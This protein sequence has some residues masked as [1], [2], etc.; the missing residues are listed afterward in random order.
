M[1]E[2]RQ[3]KPRPDFPLFPHRNGQWA[4][5]VR[6]RL[7]YFGRDPDAALAK[8]LDQKD[9][10]LA[11][12]SPRSKSDAEILV[13][14]AVN[15]VL[16]AKE[17][18]VESHELSPYT[19]SQYHGICKLIVGRLGNRRVVDLRPDDFIALRSAFAK[20]VGLV[21]LGNRIRIT[22]IVFRHAF[23][24]EL[25]E[26]PVKFGPTFKVPSKK[27]L[28]ADK[29]TR[30][31]RMLEGDQLREI[32]KAAKGPFKA[33][34]LLGLNC[35]FG[36][37]DIASLPRSAI[38]WK[39]GWLSFPRIKTAVDRRCCLWPE[40]LAA[41][42]DVIATGRTAADAADADLIFLT[43]HE[44]RYVRHY[45][46]ETGMKIDGF[47]VNF[48]KILKSLKFDKSGVGFC[49]LRHVFATIAGESQDQVAVN[50]L[51]GHQPPDDE[52]PSRYRERISDDRLKAITERVRAWLWPNPVK[53]KKPKSK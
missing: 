26:K 51:M 19:W 16:S 5:K 43:Q 23:D 47:G 31:K 50:A 30:P 21:S 8:W 18:L 27:N 24:A 53:A 33:A 35:A 6:G 25:I 32:I 4:K 28:R 13:K 3:E 11:G 22:R 41:L 7:F 9:D 38:D 15:E 52:M 44:R 20:G 1:T 37:S 42:N 39:T 29:N 40:T 36:Q 2:K 34:I 17:A 46:I 48:S 12:R 10:L 14:D 45:G 49:S